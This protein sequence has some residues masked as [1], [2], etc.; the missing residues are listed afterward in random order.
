MYD[1]YEAIENL[2]G[3]ESESD[4]PY[5][6][7]DEKCHIDSDKVKAQVTDSV[8][9]TTDESDMAQWL[10]KNGPISVGVNAFAMQVWSHALDINH[11]S[12]DA[13]SF[14]NFVRLQFYM[15][16]VSHPAK[17]LCNPNDLNH[18]VLIVG[19]GVGSKFAFITRNS[20]RVL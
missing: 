14:L 4:Y 18:G 1:A 5:K 13:I 2:G 7:D 15:G 6:G 10:F 17:F 8:N 20:L 19:F 12:S 16:G 3:I 9:I 11:Q